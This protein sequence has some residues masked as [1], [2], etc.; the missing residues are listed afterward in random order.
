MSRLV[1]LIATASLAGCGGLKVK[2]DSLFCVGACLHVKT[3]VEKEKGEAPK[4]LPQQP[5]E[6]PV[7]KD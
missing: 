7:T 3:D 6:G 4:D 5:D 1:I 2:T